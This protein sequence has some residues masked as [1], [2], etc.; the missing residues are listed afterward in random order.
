ME[1]DGGKIANLEGSRLSL[2]CPLAAHVHD[3]PQHVE[4]QYASCAVVAQSERTDVCA[5]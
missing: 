5:I 4:R 2:L 3:S 1:V